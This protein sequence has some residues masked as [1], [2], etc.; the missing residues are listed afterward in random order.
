MHQYCNIKLPNIILL[1]AMCCVYVQHVK[2][3]HFSIVSFVDLQ[4]VHWSPSC[5]NIYITIV[6]TTWFQHICCEFYLTFSAVSQNIYCHY[7]YHIFNVNLENRSRDLFRRFFIFCY[8]IILSALHQNQTSLVILGYFSGGIY[9]YF[10][11]SNRC[12]SF[13]L[14]F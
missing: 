6:A 12:Y 7:F 3:V 10:R 13:R 2:E 9:I 1:Y 8:S 4:A 11:L 14:D 5:P